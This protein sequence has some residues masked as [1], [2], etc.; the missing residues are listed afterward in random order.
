MGRAANIRRG[1]VVGVDGSASSLAALRW[2]A[3]EAALRNT[4]LTVVHVLP[5]P[6]QMGASATWPGIPMP[7]QVIDEHETQ[8]RGI[9]DDAVAMALDSGEHRA[10][11][12]ISGEVLGSPTLPTLVELSKEADMVVVGSRGRTWARR[13]LLGSVSSGLVHRAHCPVAVIHDEL[14]GS[15]DRGASAR[16]VVG[17]DG[18]PASEF[19]TALAFD[20]A[21]RRHSELLALHA[22]DDT[23]LS[24]TYDMEWST[25][26]AA[27]QERLAERL[28]GWQERYPDVY[29]RR[30][31]VLKQPAHH[32]IEAAESAQL[33]VVGSHGRGGFGGMPLGSVSAAVVQ[34]ARIPVIV[35]RQPRGSEAVQ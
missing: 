6:P 8:A 16:V 31:V 34:A 15:A 7:A 4:P 35:A 10:L 1:I 5:A 18:T 12:E 22:Y 3:H 2:A 26:V 32:L 24:G 33:L 11:P 30:V 13:V 28:A 21:S 27:T 23:D 14:P 17:I 25:I 19:A 29:V 20:E 9:V